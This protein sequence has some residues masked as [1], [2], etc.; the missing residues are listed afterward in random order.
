MEPLASVIRE[1]LEGRS[2][3]QNGGWM[4]RCL[5]VTF[6][7]L[8]FSILGSGAATADPWGTDTRDTGSHPDPGPH[9]Y[10]IAS[11]VS[12]DLRTAINNSAAEAIN[13]ST[14]AVAQIENCNISTPSSQTDVVWA[15]SSAT[16]TG[17]YGLST[18]AKYAVTTG[19]C[20]RS[21]ATAYSYSYNLS[22]YPNRF[23][24]MIA[25]H[26]FGHTM[27]LTHTNDYGGV[28]CMATGVLRSDAVGWRRFTDHHVTTHINGWF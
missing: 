16:P 1:N 18:C 7:L 15:E 2:R 3:L 27:G 12:A 5:A 6:A 25:C 13:A 14:Q 23:R 20:D 28:H 10:C 4:R 8:S 17:T 21:T 26:E 9:T 19:N 22:P 11:S 24:N